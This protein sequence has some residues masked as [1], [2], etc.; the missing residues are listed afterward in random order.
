MRFA[1]SQL[2]RRRPDRFNKAHITPPPASADRA[3]ISIPAILKNEETIIREW[4]LHNRN[5]GVRHFFL[6]DN[7]STDHTVEIA[8]TTLDPD[9]ITIIPWQLKVSA[10]KDDGLVHQQLLAF[11]HAIQTFGCDFQYMAFLDPDEFLV[12]LD[13]LSLDDALSNAGRPANLAI[14]WV[15]FGRNGHQTPP[16][17]G[18]GANYLMRPRHRFSDRSLVK[19]KCIVDPC[20]VTRVGIHAFETMSDGNACSNDSGYKAENAKRFSPEFLSGDKLQLNHYY[21]RSASELDAKLKRG[22][23]YPIDERR[24]AARV[25]SRVA[26]METDTIE[27]R[28]LLDLRSKA[29][30]QAWV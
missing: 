1:L 12:P 3:G 13:G 16:H 22:S 5:I 6:Y 23:N 26:R 27:D 30:D 18:V 24:Y 19:F 29:P 25:M 10:N 7:G 2:M 4:L 9:F 17:G 15:M 20:A 14:P 8:R 21:T 28:A 11:C